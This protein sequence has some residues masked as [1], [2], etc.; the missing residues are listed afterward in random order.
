M[1]KKRLKKSKNVVSKCVLD[2]CILHFL[3]KSQIRCTL[4]ASQFVIYGFI[5]ALLQVVESY[6]SLAYFVICKWCKIIRNGTQFIHTFPL[7]LNKFQT[8]L[9]FHSTEYK[10]ARVKLRL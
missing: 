7:K 4:M 2:F 8:F 9:F 6:A 10:Q 1:R 5:H 3:K